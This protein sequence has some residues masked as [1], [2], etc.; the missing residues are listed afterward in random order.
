MRV[1]LTGGGTGG[2]LYPCLA[3]AEEIRTRISCEYLYVGTEHGLE[4]SV[5]R[6]KGYPFQSVWMSGMHR[7][8]FLKNVLFP[9][10]MIVSLGQSLII[11]GRFRPDVVIGTGGY[12]SWPVITAAILLCKKTV[13]QE[14]NVFPGVVTRLLAPFVSSVHLSF[15]N[16]VTYFKK[17]SNLH[18]SGNPIR[19]DLEYP[20][21]KKA[22]GQFGLDPEKRTLLIFGGSQGARKINKAVPRLFP[23][24]ET[25][26]GQILW[27]A[28][29]NWI[30]EAREMMCDYKERVSVLAYIH[31]MPAAYDI[32]DLLI[33]RAGALTIAEITQLGLPAVFIPL[34]TAAGG[35]QLK[36]AEVLKDAGAAEI[37]LE[38]ELE[39]QKFVDLVIALIKDSSRRMEMGKKAKLFAKPEAA[40]KIVDNVFDIVNQS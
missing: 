18:I 28:G 27:A 12:V 16:A 1:I 35:H 32:S 8:K 34:V 6:K 11:V 33:C 22:Y 14:Q 38:E 7:R 2:H 10:K 5:V 17:K 19:K 30:D 9:L 4:A 37:V 23:C 29:P 25:I 40:R 21:N 15:E 24:L 39:S 20:L 31:D 36:N 13:I 3:I 26:K